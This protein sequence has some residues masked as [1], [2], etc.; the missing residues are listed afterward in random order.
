MLKW[1]V[2][3]V[4]VKSIIPVI[5]RWKTVVPELLNLLNHMLRVL[6]YRIPLLVR[7]PHHVV[8]QHARI[9]VHTLDIGI[10]ENWYVLLE[11]L[12]PIVHRLLVIIHI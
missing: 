4:F 1:S 7:L 5:G 9:L 3:R 8:A 10:F 11:L 2:H 6:S 12:G